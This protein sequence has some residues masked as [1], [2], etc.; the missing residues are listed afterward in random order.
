MGKRQKMNLTKKKMVIMKRKSKLEE[1]GKKMTVT[2]KTSTTD[3]NMIIK[4]RKSKLSLKKEFEPNL[5][6]MFN[7]NLLGPRETLFLQTKLAAESVGVL[8][9]SYNGQTESDADFI[10]QDIKNLEL[11]KVEAEGNRDGLRNV[12]LGK[13]TKKNEFDKKKM[14]IMKRKSKLE[15]LGKKMTVTK[16]T[17]ATDKNMIIK[18]RKSKL[19]LKKEFEP[20]LAI[21]FNQ[22]LLGPRETLFLQTKLAAESVGVL[23]HSGNGLNESDS[24][25]IKQD[26]K[27]LELEKVEAEVNRD[28]LRN[29][30]LGKETKKNEFDKKKN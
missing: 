11:E 21:M 24:D 26:M 23:T 18:K 6:I 30:Q 16:K 27:N 14:V 2:K 17:S 19:S 1:L 12:Q 20:N 5:A 29:V 25:F 13:E 15:E 3:K 22:N 7:Q 4:K 8:T 9:H 28:G 10:K